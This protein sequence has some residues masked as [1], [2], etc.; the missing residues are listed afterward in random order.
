MSSCLRDYKDR[1]RRLGLEQHS[2]MLNNLKMNTWVSIQGVSLVTSKDVSC[3]HQNEY[4]EFHP[5]I[6]IHVAWHNMER[7]YKN[8]RNLIKEIKKYLKKQENFLGEI[9][10]FISPWRII[11][12]SIFLYL[13][14]DNSNSFHSLLALVIFMKD[15][16]YIKENT[17]IFMRT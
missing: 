3:Q 8:N 15:E 1:Y 10:G 11:G 5:N 12:V 13:F 17:K 14:S 4:R 16:I 9:L 2:G 6:I 7:K